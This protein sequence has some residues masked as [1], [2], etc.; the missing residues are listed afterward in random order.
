MKTEKFQKIVEDAKLGLSSKEEITNAITEAEEFIKKYSGIDSKKSKNSNNKNRKPLFDTT[1]KVDKIINDQ[2]SIY[3]E[4][5]EILKEELNYYKNFKKQRCFENIRTLLKD[6]SN[7]KIGQIEK[8]ACVSLGYMSR[9]EKPDNSAEPSIEFV[10]TAAKMLGVSIDTLLLTDLSSFTPTERYLINLI[11]KLKKDT[12]EDKLEWKRDS[13][14]SLNELDGEI[15]TGLTDHF[16][17]DYKT[18]YVPGETDY[19]DQIDRAVFNSRSFGSDTYINDDCFSL[20]MKSGSTLYL[21]DIKKVSYRAK[22][23]D[24]YAK[25]I[26]IFTPG[27]GRQ[28]LLDNKHNYQIASLVDLL[29]QTVKEDS[30]HPKVKKSIKKVLDAFINEDDLGENDEPD[31]PF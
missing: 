17:F 3:K 27:E 10:A 8:E 20:N 19:P 4:G 23:P 26:W 11:E 30:H 22:D 14:S 21:M 29:F 9:L 16:L 18:V 5:I 24:I 13:A 28:F 15:K 25:E 31:L 2:L 7:V 1:L 6:N 12:I